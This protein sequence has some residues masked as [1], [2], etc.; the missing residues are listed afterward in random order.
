MLLLLQFMPIV[1]KPYRCLGH[2]LMMCILFGYN[3]QINFY[4][5]F[6]KMNLVIFPTKVNRYR[7]SCVCYS[8][9]SFMPSIMKLYRFLG[10]DLKMCKLFGYNPQIFLVTFS[11][12]C[13]IY[14]WKLS[15]TVMREWMIYLP[16]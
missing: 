3:P 4:H 7:V 5:F 11:L 12:Y 16:S 6:Q 13:R 10:H 14:S 15:F 2:D 9:N 1:L 8:P